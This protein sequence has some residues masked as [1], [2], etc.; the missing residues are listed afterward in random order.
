MRHPRYP[1][2]PECAGPLAP[3]VRLHR[4]AAIGVAALALSAAP[5]LARPDYMPL[6]PSPHNAAAVVAHSDL[7]TPDTQDLSTPSGDRRSPD[8]KDAAAPSPIPTGSL[9]GTTSATAPKPVSSSVSSTSDSGLDWGSVGIG[10][11][12]T[13]ALMLVG[14]AGA[15]LTRRSRVNP[16]N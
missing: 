9:A 12:I 8:A 10:A 7:R 11:G 4:A 1:I 6:P 5:A 13:A 2:M 3:V 15:L 16:A 14:M